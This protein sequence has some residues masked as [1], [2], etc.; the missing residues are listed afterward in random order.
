[1]VVCACGPSYSG[2]LHTWIA[3]AQEFEVAVSYDCTIALQPGQASKT[4]FLKIKKKV[5]KVRSR[6]IAGHKECDLGL[7]Q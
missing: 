3:G 7:H 5:E 6:R 2:G 4:Q 1:M